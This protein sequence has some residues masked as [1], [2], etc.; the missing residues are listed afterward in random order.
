MCNAK[1][2]TKHT[3]V[4]NEHSESNM[5]NMDTNCAYDAH[6]ITEV[7]LEVETLNGIPVECMKTLIRLETMVASLYSAVRVHHRTQ[8]MYGSVPIDILFKPVVSGCMSK[9]ICH[10][11]D[12]HGCLRILT[13]CL[14]RAAFVQDACVPYIYVQLVKGFSDCSPVYVHNAINET[15]RLAS[16]ER[17]ERFLRLLNDAMYSRHGFVVKP[18]PNNT[19][20]SLYDMDIGAARHFINEQHE[21]ERRHRTS[22]VNRVLSTFSSTPPLSSSGEQQSTIERRLTTAE[23]VLY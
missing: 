9:G 23:T 2:N 10:A 19:P 3:P 17:V 7:V 12:I 16:L 4:H 20:Y 8:S 13:N 15:C 6:G 21:T 22:C 11:L 14:S 1:K 5:N 18:M